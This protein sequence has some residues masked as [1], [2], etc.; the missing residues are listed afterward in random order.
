M[1]DIPGGGLCENCV[2]FSISMTLLLECAASEP[3]GAYMEANICNYSRK[4]IL[5][6]INN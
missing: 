2:P 6:Q 5:H 1:T 3:T 4:S